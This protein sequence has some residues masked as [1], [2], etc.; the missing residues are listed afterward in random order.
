M[1][2]IGIDVGGMSIKSGLVENGEI[3]HKIKLKRQ[4]NMVD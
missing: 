2:K 4:I 1:Y 3:I